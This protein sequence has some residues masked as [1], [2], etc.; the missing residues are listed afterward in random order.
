MNLADDVPR[1]ILSE[2]YMR[3]PEPR[4][5]DRQMVD[6]RMLVDA[7]NQSIE[8]EEREGRRSNDS[9]GSDNRGSSALMNQMLE[10]NEPA[11]SSP[12][13]SF[14]E[15]GRSYKQSTFKPLRAGP[16]SRLSEE[17]DG[18]A[19]PKFNYNARPTTSQDRLQLLADLVNDTKPKDQ[20]TS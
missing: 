6:P 11:S 12:D 10:G 7:I 1:R 18:E 2:G 8:K 3:L 15:P 17:D 16:L 20:D 4:S 14:Y 5:D 13:A 9:S 19:D